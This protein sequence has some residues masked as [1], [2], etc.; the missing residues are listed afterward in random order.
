MGKTYYPKIATLYYKDE[1]IK[2]VEIP[3]RVQ[4]IE[5]KKYICKKC[6]I[7]TSLSGIIRGYKN[8]KDMDDMDKISFRDFGKIT[9]MIPKKFDVNDLLCPYCMKK[10]KVKLKPLIKAYITKLYRFVNVE[11]ILN[12]YTLSRWKTRPKPFPPK[13]GIEC[14]VDKL[15]QLYEDI[16]WWNT[17][18]EKECVKIVFDKKIT[19]SKLKKCFRDYQGR[20]LVKRI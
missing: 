10:L 9:Y 12:S 19:L 15:E 2:N 18:K 4:Y 6:G 16:G 1:H 14:F 8:D 7:D 13:E 17:K 20:Q 5:I 11:D 3:I